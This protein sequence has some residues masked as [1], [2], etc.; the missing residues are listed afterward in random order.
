MQQSRAIFWDNDGVLVET[1]HLYFQATRE[2]LASIDILLTERD[3]IDLFLVD[4][5]GAWHLA[6]ERGVPPDEIERLRTERNE[7]YSELLA[8]APRLAAGVTEVL[9]A[10]YGRYVMGVVTS[11][12]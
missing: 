12:R 2:T 7:R 5:R 8:E 10:L 9:D 6:Q 11:S 1:E 4:G 3:Y